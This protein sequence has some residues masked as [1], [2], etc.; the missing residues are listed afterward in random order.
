[1]TQ[2]RQEIDSNVTGYIVIKFDNVMT[3]KDNQGI[4][5]AGILSPPGNEEYPYVNANGQEYNLSF[6]KYMVS[7]VELIKS[8][9]KV[10]YDPQ[11]ATADT[12][13]GYYTINESEASSQKVF[14]NGVP[15]GSYNKIR[16]TIGVEEDGVT[17]G[18]TKLLQD[19]MFWTWNSGFIGFKVEGQSPVSPGQAEGDIVQSHNRNGFVYH[20]GGWKEPNNNRVIE[21]DFDEV[22]VSDKLRP[23]LHVIVDVSKFFNTPFQ[24]DFSKINNVHSPNFGKSYAD[25][26]LSV[27]SVD[28]VHP[29]E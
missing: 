19:E 1:M 6:V 11:L 17:L 20:I 12:R 22:V 16:F 26:I 29:S 27:F 28:H 15:S 2:V 10:H 8:N 4:Q 13:N 14:I 21:L 5:Q 9:G 24:V 18:A 7:K 25:N 3:L 23:N